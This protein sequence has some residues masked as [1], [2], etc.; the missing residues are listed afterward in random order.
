MQRIAT[1]NLRAGAG[2]VVPVGMEVA[3]WFCRRLVHPGNAEGLRCCVGAFMLTPTLS[4]IG[5]SPSG[6]IFSVRTSAA[7]VPCLQSI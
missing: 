5:E 6:K 7:V 3:K 4:E 2:V 1:N